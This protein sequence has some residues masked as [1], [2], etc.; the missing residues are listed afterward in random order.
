MAWIK[1]TKFQKYSHV[2]SSQIILDEILGI[3]RISFL[4]RESLDKIGFATEIVTSVTDLSNTIDD[5][6]SN[7]LKNI[8][9][10]KKQL[11]DVVNIDFWSH[12]FKISK[13]SFF[14]R[15]NPKTNEVLW[16]YLDLKRRVSS[17]EGL[18][19]QEIKMDSGYSIKNRKE[20]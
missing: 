2:L 20:S 8:R 18:V 17:S 14:N 11:K 16:K 12:P 4:I 15:G 13:F 5:Y 1:C 9:N 19:R 3:V 10:F 7:I 6:Q